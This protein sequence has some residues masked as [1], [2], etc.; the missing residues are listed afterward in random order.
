MTGPGR[1]IKIDEARDPD[2]GHPRPMAS[3]SD[4]A[5][6]PD[7]PDLD[8]EWQRRR[9]S[10]GLPDDLSERPWGLALSGGGIRSATFSFGLLKAL[11]RNDLFR[12][13]DLLSTVSGG[14][15]IGAMLGRLFHNP[16][17][18]PETV[19]DALGDAGARRYGVW[20][21]ANGRYLIPRGVVD[22]LF[23]VANYGRNLLGVHLELALLSLL[24]AGL[25][26]GWDLLVWGWADAMFRATAA[27]PFEA[28]GRMRWVTLVD[29]PP[30]LWL[31]LPL[32]LWIGLAY[33]AAYWVA[34]GEDR[35]RSPRQTVFTAVIVL[36]AMAL[37]LWRF[38]DW[39]PLDRPAAG[40]LTLPVEWVVL[41]VALMASW[42]A[43]L[44][45]ARWHGRGG[46]GP[47]RVRHRLTTQL[48]RW[49]GAAVVIVLLGLADVLA[50][51]I[52]H[53]HEVSQ[54]SLGAALL[55][56]IGALRAA[57]P[58]IADLPKSLAPALRRAMLGLIGVAGWSLLALVVVF[59]MSCVHRGTSALLYVQRP[60]GLDFAAAWEVLGWIVVPAL[61]LV[62]TSAG[63][64]D[65]LN[66]SSLFTFYRAR[67]MRSYL[68]AANPR[69]FVPE[70]AGAGEGTGEADDGSAC[71]A[72]GYGLGAGVGG[73]GLPPS[74]RVD[75]LHRD[76]DLPMR[77]Y[78]PHHRGGPVHLINVCINQTEDPRGGLL[79][80]D[81]KGLLMTVGPGGRT[82]VGAGGWHWPD[83]QD[84]LTL[85]SWM[86]I[87][88]AAVAPGLG[89]STRSGLA[90]ILMLSGVRL[91]YWWNGDHSR[92]VDDA[93]A[94]GNGNGDGNGNG[95][96]NGHRNGAGG[97]HWA[98]KYEQYGRELVARFSA[99]R[100]DDWF[101]S[102]GG[103]FENTAVYALLREDCE[104]IVLADCGADPR[105]S[106][107]DLENLVRKARIDLQV[108]ITFLR[109]RLETTASSGLAEAAQRGQP[110]QGLAAFGSLNELAS[111]DSQACLAL[112]RIDYRRSGRSGHLVIVK[113]NMC[114]GVPVDLVNFKADHPLFPQEP[115]T[116][117]MFSEA[118]WE[119]YFQLGETLGRQL[120]L[121]QL[122]DLRV[123]ATL[124]FVDDD[125]AL[126]VTDKDG[127]RTLQYASRRLSSRIA[128]T[129]AVSASLSLG[130]VTSVG[131][132]VWDAGQDLA[133]T[134]SLAARIEPA[135][136]KEL[137]DLFG[138]LPVS[139]A[140]ASAPD[141]RLG[142]MAT[143]LL[144]VGDAVCNERN[145]AAFKQSA[146]MTLMVT[147]T[148]QACR[149]ASAFHPSCQALLDDD[150]LPACLQQVPRV[151]C[152]PQ[153]WTRD[154][155]SD[156]SAVANCWRPPRPGDGLRGP[157]PTGEGGAAM[158]PPPR[159]SAGATIGAATPV[160]PRA[161][162]S[163][164]TAPSASGAETAARLA[165]LQRQL[166]DLEKLGV[167][168]SAASGPPDRTAG[169]TRPASDADNVC[170][171]KTVYLQI[172]GPEL[173]DE[174]RLLRQPWQALG[175]NVPPV[176]DVWDAARRAGQRRPQPYAVPTVLVPD[177]SSW[178]CARRLPPLNASPAWDVRELPGVD[179]PDVIEV[180]IPPLVRT[181]TPP[182]DRAFCYQEDDRTPGPQR[183]GLHCHATLP[184]CRDAR[185]DN[186]RR[187]QSTCQATA[188]PRELTYSR[189]WAKSWYV[190]RPTPFEAPLPELP[191]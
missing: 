160:R 145:L 45:L 135:S 79:N 36:A 128:S 20:L 68:G 33:A 177:A 44:L 158:P 60:A 113:P 24:L 104:V 87:S 170:A 81:R 7:P 166:A 6:P 37:L 15:Y 67:L 140:A 161:S 32:P 50:W 23:A 165:E 153:Y 178:A 70:G 27:A 57:L 138:K 12:R 188:M 191:R 39:L 96:A 152:V 30:P 167:P 183:Y 2:R 136:F 143:A 76:D 31:L 90:A 55:L 169:A 42:L 187:T 127:Q 129:G 144:R 17:S 185:G 41:I 112:A 52:G 133:G 54:G 103:H 53:L 26:V 109:P 40:R 179:R 114:H 69:R 4:G 119:S 101:L 155:T 134:R 56:V 108:D 43:G 131:L 18:S 83:E 146:L 120:K 92:L 189:G 159:P 116:D 102:D 22:L 107:G 72:S 171:G 121:E 139:A 168:G 35:E 48:S 147:Q 184:A 80:Q 64:R 5:R 85:G 13:F 162:G 8:S 105:Y 47:G 74:A 173:R 14:G 82:R 84:R 61:L 163:P 49:M 125:G 3:T 28:A 150:T 19:Q 89:A 46:V 117:Q 124:H 172:Y 11:A 137:T 65:F 190:M 180:W 154:Y 78:H 73:A 157:G 130:A 10:H 91:G 77:H 29:G 122:R 93:G 118:Q 175:A 94:S 34:P 86:A 156:T 106:F 97:W 62:L 88:G 95:N 1:V 100:S 63:N 66:R 142:E 176:E 99:D 58:K 174:V 59:W 51:W 148:R 126:V 186:P 71:L 182:P 111:P 9:L 16:G 149:E 38:T 21:R 98:G 164:E 25:L 141:G 75:R 123:F 151:Q 181:Q 110:A 115:T 132:A